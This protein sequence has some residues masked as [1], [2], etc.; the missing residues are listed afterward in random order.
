MTGPSSS[1]SR[2]KSPNSFERSM[3]FNVRHSTLYRYSRSVF[4]EPHTFRVWPRSGSSQR[5]LSFSL[6]IDPELVV[7]TEAED[8]EGTIS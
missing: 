4:L 3:L 1:F 5:L 7:L 8:G 2:E 6:E